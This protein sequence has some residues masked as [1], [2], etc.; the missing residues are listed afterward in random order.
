M[1]EP[2]DA[3]SSSAAAGSGMVKPSPIHE[4]F[5]FECDH[6]VSFCQSFEKTD[7]TDQTDSLLEVKLDDLENR[8][9][10]LQVA[11]ETLILSPESSNTKDFKANAKINFNVCSEAYYETRSQ[12]MDILRISE[13]SNPRHSA[14][15]SLPAQNPVNTQISDNSNIY[16]KVPPC[17]TE[18]FKGSYEEWPSFRDM[19]TAV[20]V[21]HPKLTL[22]QKLYHLRNKTK[23]CAGAIVKRYSLCDENFNLAWNALKSRY[24]NKRVLVDNQLKILFSIPVARTENSE[25]LQ[26]VHSTVNDCLCT[27]RSLDVKVD[28]WDPLLIYL[29]STK[30]PEETISQWEQSLKSHRELPSWSQMDEF[31]INRFEVVERISSFKSAKE[32]HSFPEWKSSHEPKEIQT[33]ASQ[34]KLNSFCL[35]CKKDHSIRICP[36]FREFSAQERIDFVFKNKICNNC[37][38]NNHMK[39]KCKSKNTCLSCRKSHHTLLHLD[40]T[41]NP[42]PEGKFSNTRTFGE[43]RNTSESIPKFTTDNS[44]PS[45]SPKNFSQTQANFSHNNETILLRTALVQI[46][47]QGELFTV[48]ALIDSG[49]QRTFLSEKIRNLLRIPYRRS[50]FEIGGI[51]ASTQRADKECDIVIYSKRHNIRCNLTAIVLP[52]V[53]KKL[54][55]VSFEFPLTPE[56]QELEL[57]DPNFNKSSNIDLILGND[58]ERFINLDGIKK[59]ICGIASA[60]NTIFGWVLSGPVTVETI[61]SFTTKVVPRERDDLSEILKKFWELEEVPSSVRV[62][63]SARYCEEFYSKTTTRDADGR[64]VVRLPFKEEFPQDISLGSSR[65]LA[66]GQYTRMDRSLSKDPELQEQYNTVLNEYVSMNHMEE[67][68]SEEIYSEGKYYS[69]YLPHHAVVRPDHKTTKVRVVF[70]ASRKT[71]SGF[72]L[73]DVLHSG[74]TLQTDLIATVLNWRRYRF[75]YSGDIQKMYRQIKVHPDDRPYQR[76]LFQID[77]T[78]PIKDYQLNTVTFG[79]NCAPFLAIRTLLQLAADSEKEFPQVANILRNETYVDDILFGGFSIEEAVDSRRKLISVLKSAGFPLK[80][81]TANDPKLLEGLPRDDLY[82]LD[83]LKLCESS[84]TKTL[85]IKWNALTDKFSYS[86]T[87]TEVH[88]QI[89]KRQVLSC[90]ARLFDPAGWITPIII[91]AKMLMQQLWLENSGW[92]DQISP[93]SLHTWNNLQSDLIGLN[94]VEIPR[95]IQYAPNDT[96]EIHGFCDAS[97]G[98]YCA[99]VYLR[100][101]TNTFTVFSNLFVA[102]SKVAPLKHVSL[103]RLELNG[104]LLLALLIKFVLNIVKRDIA[105]VTLWT[106]AAIVLGWLS[107]PPWSWEPYVANRTSQIHEL[108]HGAKWRYVSTHDNPADLGTRGCKPSDLM[109]NNLW[110]KGP[111]WLTNPESTWPSRN[112]IIPDLS[113]QVIKVHVTSTEENDI[114]S[115]FSSYARAL[116]VISYIFRFFYN[117]SPN[118]RN[119]HTFSK[120]ELSQ[121]EIEMTKRRLIFLTQKQAYPSEFDALLNSQ[122]ISSKST[123]FSLNPFLD[124]DKILRVNGRLTYSFLPYK[125]RYPIILPGNSDFS[126]LYLSHLHI[127]LAHAECNQMCRFVQTEYYI[128]RL[129]PRIKGIIHKC[130]TCTIYRHRPSSQIMSPLPPDRCTLSPPFHVIGT[131]FAGPFELKSSTLRRAPIIKGYV[132]V[133]VCFSTK[134]IH[135]EACSDL[136]AAAFEAAFA[137][138]VG[139]RGLPCRVYSDNG[140][141]FV[142]ASR[143]LLREFSHFLNSASSNISQKYAI[144]GFEWKF[145]PPHAPHMGGLWEAAVKSFKTHFRKLAGAHRFTFE[146]FTTLLAR[147]EGVLNS[148]PISAITEDPSDLTAL[149]PGHFLKGAPLLAF[150]EPTSPKLSLVNK[151]L[152]LKALHHQFALRWKEDYLKTMHKRYKWQRQSPNLNINDLVVVIDDLLPPHEWRLGRI[153]KTYPGPDANVRI[154]DVRTEA[155]IINRPISK[156]CYLPL[157]DT[158]N[159]PQ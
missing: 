18:V 142:G 21:S 71:N 93:E 147:I 125:E 158:S 62:P 110:W 103:P 89:S 101:Q 30:L 15:Y 133:F 149:T 106:D 35:L 150:P 75:V 100:C 7:I 91:R 146:Q 77:P 88:V 45:T 46:E 67:T 34:E 138:F 122:P 139:R 105:S 152:K 151:W 53:T 76:I 33:Y 129:K 148:R 109:G 136:S 104:A 117:T 64:Y 90:I 80:K 86:T 124:T 155:G 32:R 52:K 84:S 3:R 73:N 128:S 26:E 145:I 4:K 131:D 66:L 68:A 51:G 14:R 43:I 115:R 60:Y 12:I 82:D 72:S 99:C 13:G 56:L 23:G 44:A 108:T 36:K 137:R 69:F 111:S 153:V 159:E 28:S 20:Y 120:I 123:L 78:G 55:S 38:S 22:A 87:Q 107:K 37:L 59:N 31:L 24:E 119:S 8:W 113:K 6:L 94:A 130:K 112:P 41:T 154:A 58:C 10:K 132:C 116:R 85:G 143:A 65:F 39:N 48:R 19:F 92:D 102:K 141:N 126:R 74:P 57:A 144:H 29:I 54:P 98:A 63:P 157:S 81:I 49:S 40:Q 140:R 114:L 9:K 70:N 16:I 83:L 11:Y 79:I 1:T 156:L 25:S 2:T 97:K 61:S 121:S 47:N 27:L 5:L 42:K 50:L 135:L 96:L 95:W 118:L 127:F 134:A 17:D